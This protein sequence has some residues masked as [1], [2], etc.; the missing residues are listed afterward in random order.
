MEAAGSGRTLRYAAWRNVP[1]HTSSDGY[2]VTSKLLI[3][4]PFLEG[5]F[6]RPEVLSRERAR[7]PSGMTETALTV[8]VHGSRVRLAGHA[9]FP[10][11]DV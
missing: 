3:G 10:M 11:V 8:S 9:I 5:A 2:A 1:R 7:D 6:Q 4:S